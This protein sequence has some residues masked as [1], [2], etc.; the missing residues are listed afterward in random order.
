MDTFLE[1]ANEMNDQYRQRFQKYVK[2][3]IKK[4]EEQ[5]FMETKRKSMPFLEEDVDNPS[6]GTFFDNCLGSIMFQVI[7]NLHESTDYDDILRM[8]KRRLL[9]VFPELASEGTL[10]SVSTSINHIVNKHLSSTQATF[11]PDFATDL[12]KYSFMRIKTNEK[13]EIETYKKRVQDLYQNED[14]QSV[15]NIIEELMKRETKEVFPATARKVSKILHLAV[16]A[17]SFERFCV[18]KLRDTETDKNQLPQPIGARPRP[19]YM[20]ASEKYFDVLYG[21]KNTNYKGLNFHPG[22][23]T[24]KEGAT[25]FVVGTVTNSVSVGYPS[26]GSAGV[27]SVA[28]KLQTITYPGSHIYDMWFDQGDDLL[29]IFKNAKQNKSESQQAEDKLTNFLMKDFWPTVIVWVQPFFIFAP[30]GR[31][32][33]RTFF[34]PEQTR[35]ADRVKVQQWVEM[36]GNLTNDCFR[37]YNRYRADITAKR[38]KKIFHATDPSSYFVDELQYLTV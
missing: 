6:L 18:E 13:V 5:A 16:V 28:N 11:E 10:S 3:N 7:N 38:V 2:E 32:V 27:G 37:T 30:T 8:Y 9:S 22:R 15:C 26:G 23:R 34:K 29:E 14:V 12:I 33:L 31:T 25:R 4:E 21:K 19:N 35:K 36:T 17:M 20:F 1:K 24:K